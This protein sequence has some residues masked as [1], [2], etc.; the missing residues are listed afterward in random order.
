MYFIK[1]L[2]FYLK[3]FIMIKFNRKKS[4]DSLDEIEDYEDDFE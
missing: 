2:H 1:I 3:I 4:E